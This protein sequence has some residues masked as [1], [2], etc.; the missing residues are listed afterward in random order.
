MAGSSI[1]AFAN[2]DTPVIKGH[3][4]PRNCRMM[5]LQHATDASGPATFSPPQSPTPSTAGSQKRNDTATYSNQ[6]RLFTPRR[7]TY[8][9]RTN[10]TDSSE[11][12]SLVDTLRVPR[13]RPGSQDTPEPTPNSNPSWAPD[14]TS[15]WHDST[16]SHYADRLRSISQ[17]HSPTL[18][19]TFARARGTR[20][21]SPAASVRS[22]TPTTPGSLTISFLASKMAALTALASPSIT[23]N[24]CGDELIDLDIEAALFPEGAPLEDEFVSPAA[25]KNLQANALGLLHRFQATYQSQTIEFRT[26]KAEREAL[27]DEK[28][29]AETRAR[30]AKLQLDEIASKATERAIAMQ[31]YIDELRRENKALLQGAHS[32]VTMSED[33]GVEEDQV[34]T[35]WRRSDDTYKTEPGSD[36]DGESVGS[37]SVFSRS[38]S[39]TTATT[40]SE[41][42][43]FEPLSRGRISVPGAPT[44]TL[45]QQRPQQMTAFRKLMK[46]ISG[47]ADARTC[48]NCHGQ[49]ASIAWDTAGLMRDENRGLKMRVTELESALDSALDIVNG[50][51]ISNSV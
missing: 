32:P 8:T 28:S 42:G 38:R 6:G 23:G 2:G 16:L 30:H 25:Y 3:E 5:D 37:V 13:T 21:S 34:K 9:R 50:L 29:E 40:V 14:I 19:T 7:P 43:S 39:P 31:T 20:E 45:P 17:L 51:E 41:I 27:E 22:R 1:T 10:L 44:H 15:A 26:L 11:P 33:L 24:G 36:T 48:S 35:R 4:Q 49:D 46:G 12:R 47:E 18:Y